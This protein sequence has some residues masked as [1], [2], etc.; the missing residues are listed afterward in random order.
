M[1]VTVTGRHIDVGQSLRQH[2]ETALSDA[3]GKFF[4]KALEGTVTFDKRGHEF[5]ADIKVHVSR[6]LYVQGEGD[7]NDP[8]I[9]FNTASEHIAK[10]LRR[11]KRRIRDHHTAQSRD[12]E[13]LTAQQ[14]ILAHEDEPEDD[15][16]TASPGGSA[17]DTESEEPVVVAE[18]KT[19]IASMTVGEAVMR[20]DLANVPAMMFRNV[21][22]GGLNM[23]YRRDDG[24]VGW[25][26]PAGAAETR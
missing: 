13:T 18:M 22:H 2:V 14:Y 26:D 9:A 3:V 24:N 11:H 5:T 8:Y 17:T 16:A 20:M 21:A 7:A 6:G 25:V 15:Q 23:I 4:E 10:R 12:L 19:D 1:K